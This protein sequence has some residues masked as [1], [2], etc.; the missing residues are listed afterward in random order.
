[1]KNLFLFVIIAACCLPACKKGENDPFLSLRSR[2]AR[3]TGKWI[4]TEKI[5][6]RLA[7]GDNEFIYPESQ[8]LSFEGD[9]ATFTYSSPFISYTSTSSYSSTLTIDKDGTYLWAV[10]EGG[11]SSQ[12]S[13]IWSFLDGTKNKVSLVMRDLYVI[14][15][16]TNKELILKRDGYSSSSSFIPPS[17]SKISSSETLTFKKE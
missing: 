14:D 4:L 1:M 13:D 12:V 8:S 3:I 10:K 7:D 6:E 2:K 11:A 17:W 9:S 5:Y 16:L 15:R